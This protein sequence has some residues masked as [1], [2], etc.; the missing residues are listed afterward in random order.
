MFTFKCPDCGEENPISP[1]DAKFCH[2]CG[3]PF[4]ELT[5]KE[6]NARFEECCVCH[7][8][9]IKGTIFC[10]FDGTNIAKR[11]KILDEYDKA[12]KE[13]GEL[14][15]NK[16]YSKWN[17]RCWIVFSVT[18]IGPLFTL[19]ASTYGSV[20]NQTDPKLI[21]LTEWVCLL[22]MILPF[23]GSGLMAVGLLIIRAMYSIRYGLKYEESRPVLPD[24]VKK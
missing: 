5:L 13:W 19:L 6:R 7:H 23:L 22:G 2:Q 4:P 24:N 17:S 16:W 14:P 21:K 10:P 8:D 20:I 9:H 3:K 1:Y 15:Q 18:L 12:T 11:R